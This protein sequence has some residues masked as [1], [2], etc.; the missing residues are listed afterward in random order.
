MVKEYDQAAY[1]H[2]AYLT[3]MQSTSCKISGWMNHK[4]ESRLPGEISTASNETTLMAESEDELKSLLMR[5]KEGSEN[6]SLKLNIKKKKKKTEI[7]ASNPITSWQVEEKR[8]K[9]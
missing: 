6:S 4:L 9:Q 3:Y 7:M 5:V 1:F 2:L 8:W